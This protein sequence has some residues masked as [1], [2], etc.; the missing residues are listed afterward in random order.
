MGYGCRLWGI[1]KQ[2][3]PRAEGVHLPTRGAT[4]A[5]CRITAPPAL[6]AL[7]DTPLAVRA[8]RCFRHELLHPRP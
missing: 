5:T 6:R 1:C 2:W 7:R 3:G 8:P 4:S